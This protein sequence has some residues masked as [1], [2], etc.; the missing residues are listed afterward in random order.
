[1]TIFPEYLLIQTTSYCNASCMI[2]PYSSTVRIQSQGTMEDAVFKKIIDEAASHG[3]H[4]RQVMPYL[5]NEPLLDADV[6]AKTYYVRERLPHAHIH[7]VTNGILLDQEYARKILDSPIDSI[8]ISVLA[9]EEKK[10]HRVM[11]AGNFTEIWERITR[12]AEHARHAKGRDY[13][14]VSLTRTPG[15]VDAA[16]AAKFRAYWEKKDIACEVIERPISRAG[17]V[18]DLALTPRAKLRGCTS[19]WRESMAHILYNGDVVL[20]CMDWRREVVLGNVAA[21]SLEKIWTGQRYAATREYIAG[22][23]RAPESFLCYRCEC[24][25]EE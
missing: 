21:D 16:H 14:L 7:I 1:M 8:K 4:V 15:E 3:V 5:M 13:C 22:M 17:N 11:G 10:Y 23:R 12:F 25:S 9:C 6:V 18:K 19:M 2:C 20:C 24:A